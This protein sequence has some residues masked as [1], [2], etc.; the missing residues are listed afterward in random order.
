M[1]K[2]TK[3][4]SLRH[5]NSTRRR[6]KKIHLKHCSTHTGKPEAPK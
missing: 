3:I 6:K 2:K 4:P 5:K 1:E